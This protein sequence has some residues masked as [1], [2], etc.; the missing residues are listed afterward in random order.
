MDYYNLGKVYYSL[1]DYVKADT[2]LA[3]FNLLQPDYIPG[4][5]WRARTKSN[6][7]LKDPK[8]FN[9]TGYAVPV[10]EGLIEKTQSDTVKYMKERF[11]SFDYLAFYHYSQFSRDQKL[12]DEAEKA[13]GF[14][15]RMS[16]VNPNDEKVAIVKPVIDAL[17]LKIK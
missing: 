12:K 9:T 1:Q 3:I 14:Y 8:G 7:D 17:K 13:L 2:N 10:Y 5:A 6:I 11:E 4:Y 16:A 15:L